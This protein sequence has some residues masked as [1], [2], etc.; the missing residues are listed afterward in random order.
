MDPTRVPVIIGVGQ[1]IER[2]AIVDVIELAARA[3][4]IALDEAAGVRGRI[5]RV[6]MVGV[7]FS[8]VSN[9]PASQHPK[10]LGLT[11]AHCEVTTAG[12]NMPQWLVTRAAQDIASGQLDATLIAGAEATRSMRAADPEADFMRASFGPKKDGPKDEVVGPN[13]SGLVNEAEIHARLFVPGEVYALLESA[14]AHAAGRNFEEQR[15]FLGPMMSHLSQVASRNPFAWFQRER[16]P[17]EISG[18]SSENRLIAEPY[19][20]RMNSF[21]S[22]DQASAV[23]LTSL[24]VAREAGLADQCVFVWSGATVSESPVSTR[25]DLGDSQAIR[26]AS[27]AVLS[28]AGIGADELSFIDLYSCFPIAVQMGARALGIALDD[29]RGLTITGGMPFFGGPGNNYSGHAIA[30]MVGRLRED[31]GLGYVGANGGFLSKHSM[32]VYG[33]SPPP[34]GFA[35]SDTDAAQAAVVKAA[36][37][38]ATDVTGAARVVAST[39][40]YDRAGSV[41]S[42]PVV[43]ALDDGRRVVAKPAPALVGDLAGRCLIGERVRV[44]GSPMI[45][46]L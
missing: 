29:P 16:T 15:R 17:E 6:S 21:P 25:V 31:S 2:D 45:Y 30:D 18:V 42:A 28:S 1:A 40:V 27:A 39:V 33:A 36:L 20:K 3:A 32:G 7:T 22:V 10:R 14:N 44:S 38:I 13:L 4:D 43:A 26:A 34:Q 24:A 35:V 5:G 46:E 37:P 19:A 9:A 8:P 12:G 41:A 11:D 23:V